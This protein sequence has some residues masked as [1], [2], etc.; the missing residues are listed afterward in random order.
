MH[1]LTT[2]TTVG[3]I[4]AHD[5]RS[6]AIFVRHGIDFCCGG[7]RSLGDACR[8]KGVDAGDI[9]RE[10]DSLNHSRT[11]DAA[12]WP[13]DSLIDYIVG[14]HHAYVRRQIPALRTMLE[15]VTASHGGDHPDVAAVEAVFADLASDLERHMQKEERILFPYVR[16]LVK[17]K[18]SG[19]RML[20]SP[21]GT[22]RN[23]I[24]MMEVEHSGAGEDMR[25]IRG[26]TGDYQP[27]EGACVTWR[28]CYGELQE[29]ERDLHE[30]VHLENNVL[31][32]AAVRLEEELSL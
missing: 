6:A 17:T 10:L 26:L 5:L 21:F 1:E 20:A 24:R 30:H 12:A 32:P 3:D 16:A 29:F 27:P 25:S 2:A 14:M 11:F 28:A 31:F 18:A 23:P 7:R 13:L 4:V 8:A 15:K 19:D 9:I 22:V